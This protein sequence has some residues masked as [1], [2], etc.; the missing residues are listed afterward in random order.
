[1]ADCPLVTVIVNCFNH[2]AFLEECLESVR[3]QTYPAV[4]LIVMD[5]CS[6]DGSA[7]LIRGWRQRTATD[8]AVVVNPANRGLAA[9]RNQG[10]EMARGSYVSWISTDDAWFPDKI[11]RQVERMESL[12][13]GVG[14][15]YS[16]A[17][18][19]DVDG[20]RLPET[21]LA[22]ELRGA[23]PPEGDI[24][25]RLAADNFIPSM[26]T[27][28][29]RRCLSDAGGYDVH[30]PIED[31]GLW[32]R[33]ASLTRFAFSPLVSARYRIVPGSRVSTLTLRDD[34]ESRLR[35]ARRNLGHQRDADPKLRAGVAR[36]A[37]YLYRSSY[38][39]HLGMLW[40]AVPV[41]RSARVAAEAVLASA[42]VPHR[43]AAAAK[44]AVSRLGVRV[45]AGTGAPPAT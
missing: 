15:I 23:P 38:P 11:E 3:C 12:P 33:L 20:R 10:L 36:A 37:D 24:F 31:W 13:P 14:V 22:K 40:R 43:R 8:C 16:D 30:V 18:R 41:A 39:G 29:R 19:V 4:Q 6:T 32:V 35:V 17:L 45:R 1:M 5:D 27:M 21:F 26:A 28:V 34:F 7:E 42:G 9:T 44:A 25:A 2:A